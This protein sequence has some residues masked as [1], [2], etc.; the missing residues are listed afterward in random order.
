MVVLEA[1]WARGKTQLV[2]M[3]DETSFVTLRN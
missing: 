1:A 2:A 3:A